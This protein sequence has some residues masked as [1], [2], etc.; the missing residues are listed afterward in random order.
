MWAKLQVSITAIST[1]KEG[2]SGTWSHHYDQAS[3][4][5]RNSRLDYCNELLATFLNQ[6]SHSYNES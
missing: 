1:F 2:A 6:P 3:L 4:C 5:S